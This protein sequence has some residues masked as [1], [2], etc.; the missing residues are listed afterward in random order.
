MQEYERI[1]AKLELLQKIDV[2]TNIQMTFIR[3][4]KMKGLLRLLKERG[5]YLQQL[6]VL[7]REFAAREGN[8][9]TT[10]EIQDLLRQIKMLQEKIV[11]DNNA[12]LEAAQAEQ[13]SIA[14]DLKQVNARKRLRTSYDYQWIKFS[15]SQLNQ[16]G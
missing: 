4:R 1:K 9:I 11:R 14:A 15:G 3:Q 10:Q 5:Q 8:S 13:A 16:R 12:V 2:N 6:E 7:N